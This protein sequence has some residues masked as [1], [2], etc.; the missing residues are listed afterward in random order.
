MNARSL[1][2]DARRRHTPRRNEPGFALL[3]DLEQLLLVAV[4]AIAQDPLAGD[5]PN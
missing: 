4:E 1:G 5:L 3:H 2:F